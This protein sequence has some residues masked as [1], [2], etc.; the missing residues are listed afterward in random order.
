MGF[1]NKYPYTSF[2][3][4]NLDWVIQ[5]IMALHHDYDEFKAVNTITNAGAWDITK[6]YQAWTIVS[7][8]NAGYIS[9]KQVPAGVAIT[10][11]EY[12]G[13]IAD[14]NILITD[15]SQ[16]IGSLENSRSTYYINVK[17]LGAKGDGVTDDTGVFTDAITEAVSTGKGIYI[18]VGNYLVEPLDFSGVTKILGES[19]YYSRLICK[20][21]CS[22]FITIASALVN[23]SSLYID[24]NSNADVAIDTSYPTQGP[25]LNSVYDY[26]RVVGFNSL[27]WK[28]YNN[29]DVWFYNN[30]IVEPATAN[31]PAFDS[32]SAGGPITISNCN[33]LSGTTI[34]DGQYVSL[35]NNVLKGVHVAGSSFNILT[36]NGNYLYP[37]PVG[38]NITLDDG[39]TCEGINFIGTHIETAGN[40]VIG[41]SGKISSQ[42]IE[43][44]GCHIFSPSNTSVNF[45]DTG[46][47]V[48]YYLCT[49]MIVGG[50]FNHVTFNTPNS[51]WRYY[52]LNDLPLPEKLVRSKKTITLNSGASGNISFTL[53]NE[54]PA[55]ATVIGFRIDF[56][57]GE[58]GTP[59]SYQV[60]DNG[61]GTTI[62]NTFQVKVTSGTSG[63]P[64]TF[65]LF[66]EI[67]YR[68]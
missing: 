7:D 42:G 24:G 64:V 43:L 10:N 31:A 68:T 9:L 50:Y 51:Y 40:A 53:S 45:I 48:P 21:V 8:N 66:Y 22:T 52:N 62:P 4:L 5:Q 67:I 55:G 60:I 56:I 17:D 13:L 12:W 14:Y 37:D 32:H 59:A 1:V 49:I 63:G 46:A 30:Q 3:E 20:D 36:L 25:S 61:A 16:R 35:I 57:K 2:H 15:L 18:P 26:I 54:I 44:I 41:G 19:G 28:A 29:N 58:Y 34:L 23:M 6:Q 11:T 47:G 33:F 38:Y 65:T 27:G 39:C